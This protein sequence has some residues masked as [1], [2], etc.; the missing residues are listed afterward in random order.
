MYTLK[1]N[2]LVFDNALEIA[3]VYIFNQQYYFSYSLNTNEQVVDGLRP[4]ISNEV[5]KFP[6]GARLSIVSKE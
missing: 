3:S 6:S 4:R 1:I 5:V 2:L